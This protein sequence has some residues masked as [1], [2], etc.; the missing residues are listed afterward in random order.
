MG[1]QK[2]SFRILLGLFQR[3]SDPKTETAYAARRPGTR[4]M[5]SQILVIAGTDNIY[6]Y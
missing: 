3:G 2:D 1:S 6:S 5:F 4:L